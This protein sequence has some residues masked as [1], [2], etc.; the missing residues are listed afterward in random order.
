MAAMSTNQ[1]ETQLWGYTETRG[2]SGMHWGKSAGAICLG[3]PESTFAVGS[4]HGMRWRSIHQP[5]Y[6]V[7]TLHTRRHTASEEIC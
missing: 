4:E 3:F 1:K 5:T 7:A 2:C 6:D